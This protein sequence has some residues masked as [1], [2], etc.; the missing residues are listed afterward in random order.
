[1][2]FISDI[3]P[4]IFYLFFSMIDLNFIPL[5]SRISV[6][7]S[8]SPSKI[9]LYPQPEAKFLGVRIISVL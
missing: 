5:F 1:M 7:I 6:A 3:Y 2:N 8:I 9:K 4:L